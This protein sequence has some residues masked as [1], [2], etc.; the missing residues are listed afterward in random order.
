MRLFIYFFI[1]V[2]K[3]HSPYFV[4]GGLNSWQVKVV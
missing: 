2:S 1:G 4:S 3:M